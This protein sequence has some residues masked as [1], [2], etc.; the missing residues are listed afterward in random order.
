[1]ARR[2]IARVLIGTTRIVHLA[3]VLA[4]IPGH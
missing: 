3:E 4:M 2:E 1:L